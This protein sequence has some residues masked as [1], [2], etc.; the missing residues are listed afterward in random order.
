MPAGN[1]GRPPGEVRL[2]T[3]RH[4][5]VHQYGAGKSG[6]TVRPPHHRGEAVTMNYS[7]SAAKIIWGVGGRG[8]CHPDENVAG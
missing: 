8:W 4:G 2:S 1:I 7:E 5:A 6:H 3:P